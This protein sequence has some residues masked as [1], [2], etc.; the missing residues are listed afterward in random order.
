MLLFLTVAIFVATLGLI[1][2]AGYFF[3]AVPMSKRQ[4]MTRLVRLE[5]VSTSRAE[6][7]DVLRNEK[8]SDIPLL[9]DL[10]TSTPG[11]PQLKLFLQQASV[12]LQVGSFLLIVVSLA[13]LGLTISATLGLPSLTKLPLVIILSGIPF[14]VVSIKRRRRL[15]RFEELFPEAID[16]LTR[17]VR[18]SHAFT[19]GFEMIGTEMP[20]PLGEEFRL[21]YQQQ[22]LGLPL[23][24]ALQN[25]IIR[26]PLPDVRIFVSAIQIQRESGGNLA[27]I[28]ETLSGV[29]RERFKL[30]RQVRTHTAEGR[31]TM[32]VLTALPF[33]TGFLLFLTKPEYIKLLF[34]DPR[35]HAALAVAAGLQIVGYF[36]IGRII[37]IRV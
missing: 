25:L 17:A 4:L 32:Y 5:E 16:L 7:S 8:L 9:N 3:I 29:I 37:R 18:S 34:T 1:V 23:R 10:L 15:A 31:M 28:L 30:I 33:A 20:D 36:V 12:R 26:V 22:K 21:T 27:E 35:G 19:T 6:T 13:L 14:F 24:E 2:S 11:I